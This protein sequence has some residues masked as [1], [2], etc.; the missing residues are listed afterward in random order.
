MS[1]SINFIVAKEQ[2]GAAY[3]VRPEQG[4]L[5][6]IMSGEGNSGKMRQ[7]STDGNT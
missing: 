1:V 4:K 5:N 2:R 6:M 7:S 3:R